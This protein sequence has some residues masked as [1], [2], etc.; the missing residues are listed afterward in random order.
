MELNEED[1][2]WPYLG[3]VGQEEMCHGPPSIMA[4]VVLQLLMGLLS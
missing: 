1:A 4:S 3:Q 2:L